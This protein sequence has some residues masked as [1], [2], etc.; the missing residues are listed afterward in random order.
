MATM[1]ILCAALTATYQPEWNNAAAAWSTAAFIWIYVGFFGGSWG[2]VSWT[3]ISEVFPLST[4]AHGVALGASANWMT[5]VSGV[6]R[7]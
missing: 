7:L 2:P 5:N 1:L 4:R 6:S 3:V